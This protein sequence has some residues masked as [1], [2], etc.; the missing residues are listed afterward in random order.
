MDWQ[1]P[2]DYEYLKKLNNKGWAWEFIRR[3]RQYR[4]IYY[5]FVENAP[6]KQV[7]VRYIP[8]KESQTESNVAWRKRAKGMGLEPFAITASQDRARHWGLLDM[9]A[10][11]LRYDKNQISF[12]IRNP[13]PVLYRSYDAVRELFSLPEVTEA[14]S[15]ERFVFVAF[16][17]GRKLDEQ[18]ERVK[19][20]LNVHTKRILGNN[21]KNTSF[22]KDAWRLYIRFLDAL[23]ADTVLSNS[24]IYRKIQTLHVSKH[25]INDL[26]SE[27]KKSALAMTENGYEAILEDIFKS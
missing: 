18:I 16:D 17:A 1:K 21:R 8:L 13:F 4:S 24:D 7:I 25:R 27:T 3:S 14:Y 20:L 19:P 23:D 11:E 10:P 26:A 5:P 9:Y 15:R 6:E 22:H 2:E 12:G